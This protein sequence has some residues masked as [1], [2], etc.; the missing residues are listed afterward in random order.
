MSHHALCGLVLATS[1][2]SASSAFADTRGH[3][4]LGL[5]LF[6]RSGT[7]ADEHDARGF[8]PFGGPTL[9]IGFIHYLERLPYLGFG[10]GVRGT[11]GNSSQAEQEYFFNP[12]F[13]S[14]TVAGFLPIGPHASGFELQIDVGFT[15]I[16]AKSRTPSA[17]GGTDVFHEYGI[18]LGVGIL[19]GYRMDFG[20]A[21][22]LTLSVQHSRHWASV[23]SPSA[24]SKTWALGST[25]FLLGFSFAGAH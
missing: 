12:I 25:V 7:L 14:A 15:N 18:G 5:A 13:T 16:L 4:Q 2:F 11:F 22:A 23:E 8:S 6:D 19:L 17:S 1:L 3:A 24:E 10:A 21:T 20:A 9:R